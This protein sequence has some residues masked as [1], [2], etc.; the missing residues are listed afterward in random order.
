MKKRSIRWQ[1]IEADKAAFARR[2]RV[3]KPRVTSEQVHAALNL[4][5]PSESASQPPQERREDSAGQQAEA[6]QNGRKAQET[7]F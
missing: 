5:K 2:L 1:H 4:L 3:A 7:A 6:D